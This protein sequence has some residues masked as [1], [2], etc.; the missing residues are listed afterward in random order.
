MVEEGKVR[1]YRGLW[2]FHHVPRSPSSCVRNRGFVPLVLSAMWNGQSFESSARYPRVGRVGDVQTSPTA[3]IK[4]GLLAPKAR[5]SGAESIS[6]PKSLR[7]PE[8]PDVPSLA[9]IDHS[10]IFYTLQS[11]THPRPATGNEASI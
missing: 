6:P 2:C 7:L 5:G 9:Y 3:G 11:R 10:V 1:T 8:R 4:I